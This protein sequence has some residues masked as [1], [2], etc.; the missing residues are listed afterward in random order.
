MAQPRLMTMTSPEGE[1]EIDLAGV[2]GAVGE[3]AYVWDVASDRLSWSDNARAVLGLG[4][5]ARIDTGAR[6]AA[7]FDPEALTTR[8]EAVFGA[9]ETDEGEGVVFEVDYP[10]T[11][12]GRVARLWIEDRGRWRAGPDG[13]PAEVVGMV[14]RL[15]ARY[16]CAERA[17]TLSRFDPLTGQLSRLRLIEVAAAA[18]SAGARMQ[19]ATSFVLAAVVNLGAINEAYGFDVGDL[20]LIEVSRRLK[21][22]MR[23]GDTLGRYSTSTFGM[24]LQE[25]DRADVE[26]AVRRFAAAV[27][28]VPV[29]TPVGPVAVRVA[30]G[31]VVAPRHARDVDE[32]VTRARFALTRASDTPAAFNIY[33]P[34][35]EREAARRAN[36]RLADELVSA[37]NGR[38]IRLALQPVVSAATGETCWSE[39]L[40]RIVTADGSVVSGGPLASAAEEVG[41][42]HM[43]DRRVLDLAITHL[44]RNPEARIAVN[45]SATTTADEAWTEALENWA[46]LRPDAAERLMV[47]ITETA[48]IA[49]LGVTTRFVKNL[50]ARGIRVAID[51]FGTG[52]SSFKALKELEVDLVKIDGSF[53]RDLASLADSGAFVR[54]LIALA[55][56]LGFETVAE[57]VESR[58]A[59]DMLRKWG[60]TYLQGDHLAPPLLT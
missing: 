1:P 48:A 28:D 54:A 58:E 36:M 20:A 22:A 25:C 60:A 9:R 7:L 33:T 4:P 3:A 57:Q 26:V 8:R 47:E 27:H 29:S 50:K 13:R 45:V 46:H 18:L 11:R 5:E 44:A 21:A 42:V 41:L 19:T 16:E 2:L 31:A 43:L 49:D 38:K 52:H 12:G 56:E 37:L 23:G 14:R 30:I 34:D 15:G 35:P 6:F 17:A 39:A 24:V 10:L 59:A 53:V 51:D 40:V 55:R 32:M